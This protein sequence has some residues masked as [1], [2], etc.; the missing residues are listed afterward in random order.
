METC[1]NNCTGGLKS[2]KLLLVVAACTVLML[3][4]QTTNAQRR[5]SV[6]LRPGANVATQKLGGANLDT[7]FG[8]EGSVA[9]RFLPH[10]AAY[11]GWSWNKFQASESLAGSNV[12]FEETGYLFGLQF[13][14]PIATSRISYLLRAGG[15]YNHIE[16]ENAAGTIIN[17]TGHGLGWQAGVG[18][19]IP[20]GNRFRLIPE[21]RYRSLA[22][23]MKIDILTTPV[24][25]NFVS[26][27][28]GLSFSL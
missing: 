22:R 4:A 15:T 11:A 10:L 20:L 7:G 18:L 9:Y 13:I 16:T 26:A 6:E 12:D 24:E 28:V 23:D 14:H 19:A 3:T 1:K 5:W 27:G 8:F 17:D 21:V 25:L 2:G